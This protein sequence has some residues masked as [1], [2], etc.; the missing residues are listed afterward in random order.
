MVDIIH[1]KQID[2]GA[3]EQLNICSDKRQFC[4]KHQVN[5]VLGLQRHRLKYERHSNYWV[6]MHFEFI[7]QQN[8]K[9]NNAENNGR[10]KADDKLYLSH[11]WVFPIFLVNLYLESK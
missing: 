3:E 6:W 10:N 7:I 2:V 8:E 5:A 9:A 11:Y 4:G 1:I